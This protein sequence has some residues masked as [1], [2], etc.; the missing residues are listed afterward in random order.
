MT[1]TQGIVAAGVSMKVSHKSEKYGLQV[2]L[3]QGGNRP[4][5]QDL[6]QV[7]EEATGFIL[8]FQQKSLKEM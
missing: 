5:G 7:V 4:I 6:A 3:E 1:G 8:P 2:T